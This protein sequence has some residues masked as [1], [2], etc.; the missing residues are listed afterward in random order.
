MPGTPQH[1]P[2]PTPVRYAQNRFEVK[3][4]V[5]TSSLP[6]LLS[7]C[8]PYTA[9]DAHGDAGNGYPVFSIYWDTA[10][11]LFFWEKIEG[12]KDRRKLRFRRY[13]ASDDVFIEIK[14]RDDRT[15]QK[16]RVKWPVDRVERVFGEGRV[17]WD[18]LGDDPVAT[19]VA[20][21]IDRLRLSPSVGVRYRR[22]ALRGAFDPQLRIT[23]DSRLM[24]RPAPVDLRR[25]FDTGAYIVDPR[26]SVMEVKFAH[27]PPTWLTKLVCVHGLKMVRMSK[28]CS[29]VD[30][31]WYGGQNT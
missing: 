7:A 12:A 1:Q 9:P 18:E 28:Y 8:A 6:A 26:V 4:L 27:R 25:P 5:G 2:A 31:H 30:R 29:A 22:R 16:R 11:R 23:F 15:L 13:A 20:L 21:M 19:E 17:R 10:N 14:Q 24:Y 3:Y